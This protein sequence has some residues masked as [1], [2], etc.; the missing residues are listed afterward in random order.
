MLIFI[1]LSGNPLAIQKE[2]TKYSLEANYRYSTSIHNMYGHYY[3]SLPISREDLILLRKDL[4][5]LKVDVL[6]VDK[7]LERG[8]PSL[9][10]FDMDST[11]I[12]EEVI[13]E[14]AR[15]KGVFELVAEVT[16]EAMEGNLD[17]DS[18]LR[19]RCSY[20]DGLNES[21]F[22]EIFQGLT[23]NDGVEQVLPLIQKE[24]GIIAIFSGGFVPVIER[25]AKKF[26]IDLYSANVLEMENGFTTGR[27]LGSIVNKN[28]KRDLL[29]EHRDTNKIPISQTVAV[30][31]GSNDS[32][33]IHEAGIGIGF[34][35]KSGLKK[36]ILNWIDFHSMLSLLFLFD[37]RD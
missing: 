24:K 14:L 25:F 34:H 9:F 21:I 32:L 30:G 8:K 18:A 10:S 36:E 37:L 20:L 23:P 33:M 7:L 2:L 13:D 28:R 35:A 27:V 4:A 31:D 12:Q 29:I 15:K 11:L 5:S 26:S 16:R 22:E 6:S 3:D 1:S 19:K 17:F